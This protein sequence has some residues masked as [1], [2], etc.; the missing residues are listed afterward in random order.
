[1]P[2]RPGA[3]LGRDLKAARS[4]A[5]ESGSAGS[6]VTPLQS[7]N[8][9]GCKK[10]RMLSLGSGELNTGVQAPA[11]ILHTSLV[12]KIGGVDGVG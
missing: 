5:T 8:E 1:M 9:L 4:A 11:T 7:A 10:S 2:S 3:E 12:S 6:R